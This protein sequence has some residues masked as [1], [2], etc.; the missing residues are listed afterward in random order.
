M[1]TERTP[2]YRILVPLDGSSL[3]ESALAYAAALALPGDEVVLLHVARP[4][5]PP[6]DRRGVILPMTDQDL[7]QHEDTARQLT[8]NAA[9]IWG[10]LLPDVVHLLAFGDPASGIVAAAVQQETDLIVMAS[11]GRGALGRW[12]YGSVA[13]AVVRHATAPTMVIRP[14]DADEGFAPAPVYRFVVPLDG[15]E[16]AR[17][18]LPVVTRLAQRLHRPVRLLHVEAP[19][20]VAT[21]RFGAVTADAAARDA[22]ATA[23]RDAAEDL[24]EAAKELDL[25]GVRVQWEIDAGNPAERITANVRHGEVLVLASHG[26]SGFDRFVLGSVADKLIRTGDAPVIV[27]RPPFQLDL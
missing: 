1:T 23:E 3:A 10:R 9:A 2:P 4:A 17:Q 7:E 5:D 24:G 11:H 21:A 15:T 8:A 14:F 16:L 22:V 18:A 13:D 26:R 12:R 27:V 6:R 19:V 25:A 20:P